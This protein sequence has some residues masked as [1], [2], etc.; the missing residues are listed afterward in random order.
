MSSSARFSRNIM[1]VQVGFQDERLDLE[2]AEECLVGEW[3]GPA[4]V[5]PSEVEALVRAALDAPRGYPPLGRCVVP[6]DRVTIALDATIAD[7]TVLETLCR[8]L[9]EAAG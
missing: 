8:T 2:V 9:R 4:G 5:G 1:R 7:G 6:G 3:H